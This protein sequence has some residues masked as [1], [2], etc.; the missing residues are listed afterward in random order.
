MVR[1]IESHLEN[2]IDDLFLI[3]CE[4]MCPIVHFFRLTPNHITTISNIFSLIGIYYLHTQNPIKT[5]G[6]MVS[7]Y[8]LDCLDGHYARKYKMCSTFGDY[9]DHISDILILIVFCF[10]FWIDYSHTFFILSFTTRC[11]MFSFFA[12]FALLTGY[13]IACQETYHYHNSQKANRSQSL[14]ILRIL[15]IDKSHIRF[16][17]YFGTGSAII[18][19]YGGASII[20]AITPN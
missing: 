10:V 8:F 4:C 16:T 1:K 13:H 18:M 12:L 5:F 20:C 2:P 15:C 17:R 6:F 14:T 11:F 19:L 9:Y 7:G 3:C